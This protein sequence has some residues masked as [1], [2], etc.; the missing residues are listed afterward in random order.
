MSQSVTTPPRHRT[1]ETHVRARL[2]NKQ[3][4]HNRAQGCHPLA[5][6]EFRWDIVWIV[7]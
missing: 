1:G 2:S 5:R 3:S 7:R 6:L 4:R